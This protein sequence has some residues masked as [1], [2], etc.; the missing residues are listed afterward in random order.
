MGNVNVEGDDRDYSRV[1]EQDSGA[2][3]SPPE[4]RSQSDGGRSGHRPLT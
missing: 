4:R 1:G 3:S 2:A